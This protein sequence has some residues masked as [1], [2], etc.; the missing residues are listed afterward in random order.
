M[1]GDY[2]IPSFV[3]PEARD[4]IKRVL[5]VDHLSRFK[6]EQIREHEWFKKYNQGTSPQRGIIVGYHDIPV[7]KE[8][9]D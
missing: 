5:N 6:I 4:L 7:D 2:K 3:S 1:R 9:I 8:L